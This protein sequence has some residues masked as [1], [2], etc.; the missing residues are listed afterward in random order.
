[1]MI[2]VEEHDEELTRALED[3]VKFTFGSKMFTVNSE[4]DITKIQPILK[5]LSKGAVLLGKQFGRGV[6]LRFAVDAEVL[7]LINREYIGEPLVHQMIG[8]SSRRQ[9]LCY[10]K[11]FV[12]TKYE[13]L[14]DSQQEG[15]LEYLRTREDNYA[16]DDG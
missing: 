5:N 7:V 15:A 16:E 9:G 1:M 6:N 8:R 4:A 10:G 13:N 2:F 12:T 14:T 11:V 3:A